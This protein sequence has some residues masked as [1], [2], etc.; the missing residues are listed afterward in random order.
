MR[1]SRRKLFNMI[2]S[3]M[4]REDYQVKTGDTMYDIAK[5]LDVSLSSLIAANPQFDPAKL[6][7][8][9]RG[10]SPAPGDYVGA[11]DRNPNW[12]YP[13]D[14]LN[15]PGQ[16]GGAAPP[17][18]EGAPEAGIPFDTSGA[19]GD[20]AAKALGQEFVDQCTKEKLELLSTI[21]SFISDKKADLLN[22][23]GGE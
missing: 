6:S 8:W 7:N 4:L 22:K 13:G 20:V 5:E 10:D 9:K 21:E 11:E 18:P 19:L 12:I 2:N 16:K 23:E 3:Y 17:A 14:Q 15:V 1:M